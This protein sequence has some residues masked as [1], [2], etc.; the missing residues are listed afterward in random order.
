[1]LYGETVDY[2]KTFI[3]INKKNESFDYTLNEMSSLEMYLDE[4]HKFNQIYNSFFL[5]DNRMVYMINNYE[6]LLKKED[7]KQIVKL[8]TYFKKHNSNNC[9]LLAEFLVGYFNSINTIEYKNNVKNYKEVR[10]DFRQVVI[11]DSRIC[12]I[13]SEL[14]LKSYELYNKIIDYGLTQKDFFLGDIMERGCVNLK[15]SKELKK[16]FIKKLLKN[17]IYPSKAIIYDENVGSNKEY[18]KKYIL[19]LKNEDFYNEYPEEILFILDRE[20]LL[21]KTM[22]NTI[23]NKIIERVGILQNK[24]TD[25]K[26]NFIQIVAESDELIKVLNKYLNKIQNMNKKQKE[27]IHKC[28]KNI[29][30]IKRFIVSDQERLNAQMQEFKYEKIIP[31]KEINEFVSSVN[32][33]VGRL[34]A[35]SCGNFSKELEMALKSYSEYPVSYIFNSYNIDSDSQIYLKSDEGIED[36]IFKTYYDKKGQE[37]TRNHT[38]LRNR[39]DEGYYIQLLKYLKHSF[40]MRQHFILSFFNTKEKNRVLID[41]LISKGSYKLKNDYVILAMNVVQIENTIIEILKK[42]DGNI[43]KDGFKNLNELANDYFNDELYFNGL[44][45]INYI[46]YERHGLNIRNNI[47]HGNYF[48]KNVEVEIMTTLCAIMFLNNLSRKECGLSD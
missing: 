39:L 43:S 20:K 33:N 44:M 3:D 22:F 46:L 35:S 2:L 13:L 28:L 29:L 6:I 34:Y 37:Y 38:E 18:Y 5:F 31:H 40:L 10:K 15:I 47:S 48:K 42:K 23:L 32:E 45:Y 21:T 26:E 8:Y 17:Q 1:M 14:T 12:N 41:K 27:K 7:L 36:S 9:F 19:N 11:V 25:K 30:Y 24:V 16:K 4:L